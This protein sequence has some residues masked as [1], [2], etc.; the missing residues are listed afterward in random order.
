MVARWG[1]TAEAAAEAANFDEEDDPLEEEE[2]EE[3]EGEGEA[4]ES[5][6]AEAGVENPEA[7]SLLSS[8]QARWDLLA[9]SE[10]LW[11]RRWRAPCSALASSLLAASDLKLAAFVG[12]L[13]MKTSS[14]SRSLTSTPSI[15]MC[16]GRGKMPPVGPPRR[17]TWT[18]GA[19][20]ELVGQSDPRGV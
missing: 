14:S 7:V 1:R 10:P 2:A 12:R 5:A 9:P 8:Q 4:A 6:E 16:S 11:L 3:A 18:H 17:P 20:H 13:L 15:L 19:T